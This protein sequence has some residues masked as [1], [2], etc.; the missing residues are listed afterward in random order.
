[1]DLMT[2]QEAAQALRIST[3]ALR[4]LLEAGEIPHTRCGERSV[5]VNRQ[6]LAEWVARGGAPAPMVRD[7]SPAPA[8]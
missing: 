2:V 1:M 6:A 5:R 3:R 4:A 7:S 8:P